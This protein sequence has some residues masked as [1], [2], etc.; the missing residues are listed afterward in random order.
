MVSLDDVTPAKFF[1]KF[2]YSSDPEPGNKI[3]MS[4]GAFTQCAIWLKISLQ[5][6]AIRRKI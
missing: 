6:E 2:T 1:K 5:L 3:K 4:N